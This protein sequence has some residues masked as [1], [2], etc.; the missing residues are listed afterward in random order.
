MCGGVDPSQQGG[1]GRGRAEPAHG[2]YKREGSDYRLFPLPPHADTHGLY[3]ARDVYTPPRHRH[4]RGIQGITAQN[5][6]FPYRDPG[7]PTSLSWLQPLPLVLEH[8][9]HSSSPQGGRGRPCGTPRAEGSA[10]RGSWVELGDTT[11][12]GHAWI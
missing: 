3:T 11:P 9:Q 1:L 12:T 2:H 5:L 4:T 7:C 6:P 10:Q 8:S